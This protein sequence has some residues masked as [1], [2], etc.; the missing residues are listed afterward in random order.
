MTKPYAW[1]IDADLDDIPDKSDAGT[2]GPSDAMEGL[3]RELRGNEMGTRFL[4]QDG[5]GEVMY[6]GRFIHLDE[7]SDDKG[8]DW[9]APLR[10]FGEPQGSCTEIFY[11]T[12]TDGFRGWAML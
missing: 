1:I 6:L 2:V 9:F 8:D 3:L 12:V 11:Q 5:D 4:M 10:E 7:G